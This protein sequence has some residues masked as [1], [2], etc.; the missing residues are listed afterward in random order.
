MGGVVVAAMIGIPLFFIYQ[1]KTTVPPPRPLTRA[2]RDR[3]PLD[4]TQVNSFVTSVGLLLQIRQMPERLASDDEELQE[5]AE[6]NRGQAL[7]SYEA[8]VES[9]RQTPA[10]IRAELE[11]RVLAKVL[12]DQGEA[13]I[14]LGELFA[15]VDK[16]GS[17][18]P[19]PADE[20]PRETVEDPRQG[21][22]SKKVTPEERE[23]RL[24]AEL[25]A[26]G[27]SSTD[28]EVLRH[29]NAAK[30][31]RA[32]ARDDLSPEHRGELRRVA[33]LIAAGKD[34]NHPEVVQHLNAAMAYEAAD[35][36]GLSPNQRRH[37][38]KAGAL[39]AAGANRFGP[40]VLQHVEAAAAYGI[41][42]AE[43][44]SPDQRRE[45]H[46]A[47]DLIAEGKARDDPEVRRHVDAAAAYGAAAKSGL[48]PAQ[49]SELRQAAELIAAGKDPKDPEVR[50]HV[51][52]ATAEQRAA[53]RE[54]AAE[55]A[56]AHF[57]L[58]VCALAKEGGDPA[59][60]P[61]AAARAD[62][63]KILLVAGISE[64]DLQ[65]TLSRRVL[66]RVPRSATAAERILQ[67]IFAAQPR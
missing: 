30:A 56:S 18:E 35:G 25:I 63:E 34:R 45:L 51:D 44:L 5:V 9:R 52:A 2:Q 46:Q 17:S 32:A 49:R 41:A 20:D 64:A 31:Y 24:A 36:R 67:E 33:E 16:D 13:R 57:V 47:A 62:Y 28:P 39:I 48:S 61:L 11:Q 23:R 8:L 50:Q 10:E 66:A 14:L 65:R 53:E 4:S 1:S 6:L 59:P 27:R 7:Q 55:I 54:L 60:A 58:K 15:A 26:A 37:L 42:S 3:P 21:K 40:E 22:G 19:L 12:G 43:D 38:R 29:T